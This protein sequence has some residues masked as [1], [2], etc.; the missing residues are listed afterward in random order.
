MPS[1]GCTKFLGFTFVPHDTL[2]F[3]GGSVGIEPTCLCR[4]PGFDPWVRKICWRRKLSTHSSILDWEIPRTEEAG[5]LQSMGSTRVRHDFTTKPPPPRLEGS[6]RILTVLW[7]QICVSL[8]PRRQVSLQ[9]IFGN[10]WNVGELMNKNVF[11]LINCF[12]H[13]RFTVFTWARESSFDS[14]RHT[15]NELPCP[16]RNIPVLLKGSGQK[17][18]GPNSR[19]WSKL[20]G[21]THQCAPHVGARHTKTLSP[22]HPCSVWRARIIKDKDLPGTQGWK[23]CS[24]W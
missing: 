18:H 21:H 9:Y 8:M 17:A 11:T 7:W 20:R 22:P 1:S 16:A 23:C 3:S 2:R 5:G 10:W 19:L 14:S 13:R 24:L 4:G 6:L 15:D 12:I